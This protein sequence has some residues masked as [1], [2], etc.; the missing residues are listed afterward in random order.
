MKNKIKIGYLGPS[1]TYTERAA[2]AYSRNKKSEISPYSTIEDVFKAIIRK[3]AEAGIVPLENIVQG[4]VTETLD[5]LFDYSGRIFITDS[6]IIPISHYLGALKNQG[7]I[8]KILS[9][10]HALRQCSRYLSKNYRGAELIETKSTAAA[11]EKI[12]EEKLRDSAAI[13]D[14]E[15]I[16]SYGLEIIAE[17]IGNV[18]DNKTKFAVLGTRLRKKTGKDTTSLVIYP[19]KDRVGLLDDML[20]VISRD[21][22]LNLSSIHSRPDA[23]GKYR[24]YM[25][26]EG[27]VDDEKISSCL[28]ALKEKIKGDN[29]E[30]KILGSYPKKDL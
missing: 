7:K 20:Q 8:E 25:D 4:I 6:L 18:Q 22:K 5:Y 13:A 21:Y 14:K 24:F 28:R 10:D 30:I 27:H 17:D 9:K 23:K 3:K 15:K 16:L 19:H 12:A 1:G 11:V 2:K 26:L 29:V